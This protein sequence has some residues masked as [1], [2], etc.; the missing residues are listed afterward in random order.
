MQATSKERIL[1]KVRKALLH[2][3]P[4]KYSGLD[5]KKNIYSLPEPNGPSLDI[6]FAEQFTNVAGKFVFC[7]N[8]DEFISNLQYLIKEQNWNNLFCI[9][10]AINQLLKLGAIEFSSDE[11]SMK[12][13]DVGIT[14]CEYLIAR[15]GSIMISSKQSSG[16][17]LAVYPPVHIVLAYTSQLVTHIKDALEGIKNKYGKK[18]P[19]MIT[20]ITGPS[21][22]ADIEKTL[23]LGAHGPKE[24]YVFMIDNK[25][26]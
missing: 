9:D 17:R 19:S 8:E 26:Q 18:L 13:M 7:E 14:H 11:K 23:I 12:N 16:R 15:T 5:F 25:Q 4:A 6:V 2:Q 21:R 1:K 22:T 10:D 3:L 20:T 24:V